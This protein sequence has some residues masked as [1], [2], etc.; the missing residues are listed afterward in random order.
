MGY[1]TDFSGEILVEPPLSAE[2]IAHL[3]KF[4]TTRRMDCIKGPYYIDGTGLFGQDSEADVRDSN[5]PPKGQPGL[6]CQWVP[7]EDGK[8][9]GWDGNE[10][11]YHADK[12][13]EYIITHF[14]GS[15]PL[16]KTSLPFLQGH[17]LNGTILAQGEDITDRWQ[18][19]VKCNI[20][21]VKKLK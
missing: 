10:K 8:A 4:S 6:W 3:N 12:W 16:A 9:I 17:T 13:M 18:L 11:F 19:I 1:S 21:T 2:E 7:S 15:A 14:V 5:Q 20:V